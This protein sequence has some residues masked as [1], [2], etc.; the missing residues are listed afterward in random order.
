[1]NVFV[2]LRLQCINPAVLQCNGILY[3]L[4]NIRT[5]HAYF[6]FVVHMT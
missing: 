3:V 6:G 4:I 1:M 5:T 2:P